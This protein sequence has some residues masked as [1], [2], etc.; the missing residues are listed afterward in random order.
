MYIY[1]DESGD[2][3]F[4]FSRKKTTNF[5]VVTLLVCENQDAIKEF[6]KAVKRTLKN[7]LN[8]KNYSVHELKGTKTELGVKQYF[9]KQIKD[10]S[11]QIYT[12]V[13]NKKRVSL[14]LRSKNAKSRLYNYVSRLLLEKLP[15]GT[16]F[17]NVRLVVDRSKNT[18]EIL[19]FNNYLKSQLEALLPLNT[20]FRIEHLTSQEMAGLQAVDLFC[21]G[22]FRKYELNDCLWYNEFKDK[23]GYESEY[24]SEKYQ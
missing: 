13:L 7:K 2:L 15:L 20:S 5:F 14:D 21:W 11:W 3:G 22:I 24:L 6:E 19:D 16:T 4:D 10:D 18:K 12:L 8:R 1:L 17:S 23:I 9:Y